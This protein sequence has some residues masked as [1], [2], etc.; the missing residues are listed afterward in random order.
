MANGYI[1][2]EGDNAKL[3]GFIAGEAKGY[4]AKIVI[5]EVRYAPAADPAHPWVLAHRLPFRGVAR[6]F[7]TAGFAREH[8]ER[9]LVWAFELMGFVPKNEVDR[10]T[11]ELEELADRMEGPGK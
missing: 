4:K 10:L 8:A 2:W 6:R 3:T 7:G 11:G 5:F 9:Y 1:S